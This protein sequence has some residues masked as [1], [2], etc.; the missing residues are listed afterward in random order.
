MCSSDLAGAAGA[1]N[2]A[3]SAGPNAAGG[4]PG[5]GDPGATADGV[6]LGGLTGDGSPQSAGGDKK[7]RQVTIGDSAMRIEA[8]P[9]VPGAVG[10]QLPPGPVQQHEKGTGSGGK[11][12]SG[13]NTNKGVERGRSI[14]SGL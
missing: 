5:G 7:S 11:G 4:G 6:Q 2:G 1:A 14:P 3:G 12:A 10:A 8:G 13:S 9:P